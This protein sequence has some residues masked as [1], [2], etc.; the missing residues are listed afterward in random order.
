[1]ASPTTGLFHVG[2]LSEHFI[3]SSC[4]GFGT[5]RINTGSPPGDVDAVELF[6]ENG[7]LRYHRRLPA[8]RSYK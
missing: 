1:M 3:A 5:D 2:A 8:R 7:H 6:Q 4:D